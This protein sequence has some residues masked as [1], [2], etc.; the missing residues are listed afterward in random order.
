MYSPVNFKNLIVVG[1]GCSVNITQFVVVSKIVIVTEHYNFTEH[2][3]HSEV[4]T[5]HDNLDYVT[6]QTKGQNVILMSYI[7]SEVAQ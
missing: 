5:E 1:S 4:V 6:E 3:L 2:L 7:G